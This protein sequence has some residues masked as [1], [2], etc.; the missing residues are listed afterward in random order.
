MQ[1]SFVH[2][3][4]NWP[5]IPKIFSV[6]YLREEHDSLILTGP[7]IRTWIV[8]CS[9]KV[10][11]IGSIRRRFNV[12]WRIFAQD[13]C[14]AAGDVCTFEMINAAKITLR[15]TISRNIA[16]FGSSHA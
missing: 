12:G 16:N 8:G 5:T 2:P 14:L 7:D 11:R 15:V 6:E 13:N 9:S 1:S 3:F 10:H 4:Y